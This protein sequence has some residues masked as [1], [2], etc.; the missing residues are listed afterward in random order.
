MVKLSV[1]VGSFKMF[2][3]V[4]TKGPLHSLA[5]CQSHNGCCTLGFCS[6]MTDM[7]RWKPVNSSLFFVM[8]F[9]FFLNH[10]QEN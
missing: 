9:L 8:C 6:K 1:F 7:I 3:L 2:Q 5:C 4:L 10:H